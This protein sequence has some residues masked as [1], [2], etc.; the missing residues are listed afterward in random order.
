MSISISALKGFLLEEALAKLL[1]NSGYTLITKKVLTQK[2]LYPEFISK[3]NGLNIKGRG[4]IH[5]ADALGQFP[6][7]IPFNYPVRLFVEAKFRGKKTG[8]DVVRSA[9]GILTDLNANYQTIDLK[10]D[11]LLV[12][13]YNYHFAIFSTSGFSIDA[14][15]L[16]IA[17]KITLVDLSGAEYVALLDVIED[18][19]NELEP[20]M[21]EGAQLPHVRDFI[22]NQLFDLDTQ[23]NTL[24]ESIEES[25]LGKILKDFIYEVENFGDLYL[26]SIN[27]PFSILLKPSS[28][29]QFKRFIEDSKESSFNVSISWYREESDLWYITLNH[30][31]IIFTFRLPILLKNHI[32]KQS[33]RDQVLVTALDAKRQFFSNIVFFVKDVE[34]FVIFKYQQISGDRPFSENRPY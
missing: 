12:Q 10:G 16:A 28:S 18:T 19:A 15:K 1:E 25:D 29:R 8:I 11:S 17:Y 34:K 21:K 3:G 13:R 2:S 6:I 23:I 22:R 32:F 5:Q 7:S 26:A 24:G 27:A 4:G 33:E 14:I 9:I 20:L 30:S 31:D